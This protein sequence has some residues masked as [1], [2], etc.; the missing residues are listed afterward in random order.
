M[1]RA[2]PIRSSR[3]CWRGSSIRAAGCRRRTR[4]TR[5]SSAWRK[6]HALPICGTW[7][8]S[9]PRCSTAWVRLR[10]RS[11]EHNKVMLDAWTR[12]AGA[13]AKRLNATDRERRAAARLHAGVPDALGRDGQRGPAGDAAHRRLPGNP[14]RGA[15]GLDRPQARPADRRRV[16]QRDVR[17]SH[18]RRAR[19]R[20]Q[21]RHRIAARA[22]RVEALHAPH[23]ASIAGA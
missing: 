19:R 9:S 5:R 16:L 2:P 17:L 12:A 15:E 6:G 7:S 18:A 21:V 20:P 4:S 1:G 13:F 3:P 14:A 10:Q 22:P 23:G 8:V 11:F